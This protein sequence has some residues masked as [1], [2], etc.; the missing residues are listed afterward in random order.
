MGQSSSPDVTMNKDYVE[1]EKQIT[2]MTMEALQIPKNGC[3]N[4]RESWQKLPLEEMG[5]CNY[6]LILGYLPSASLKEKL[7]V[8]NVPLPQTTSFSGTLMTLVYLNVFL[9]SY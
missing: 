4:T 1:Y 9:V 3:Q 8:T 5:Q 2:E 6:L 7:Q